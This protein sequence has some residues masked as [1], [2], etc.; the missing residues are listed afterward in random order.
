MKIIQCCRPHSHVLQMNEQ[1][2]FSQNFGLKINTYSSDIMC[3]I[4]F[5]FTIISYKSKNSYN[6]VLVVDSELLYTLMII[7]HDLKFAILSNNSNGIQLTSYALTFLSVSIK[8]MLKI[9]MAVLFDQKF[10]FIIFIE[11]FRS[12]IIMARLLSSFYF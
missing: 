3:I 6:L 1:S 10:S 5:N 2:G 9:T 12:C 7:E 4:E 8:Y 11:N